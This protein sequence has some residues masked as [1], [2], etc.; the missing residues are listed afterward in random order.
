[1]A[2]H[3]VFKLKGVLYFDILYKRMYDLNVYLLHLRKEVEI[4]LHCG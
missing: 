2:E 3:L 4:V 1:M